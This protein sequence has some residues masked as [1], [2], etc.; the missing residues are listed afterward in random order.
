MADKGV[1]GEL[2]P[3]QLPPLRENYE[4]A[5]LEVGGDI[6]EFLQ[7]EHGKRKLI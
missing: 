1:S 4:K 5:P 6:M 2:A 7:S 3:G